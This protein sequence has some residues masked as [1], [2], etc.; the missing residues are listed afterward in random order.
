MN[1]VMLSGTGVSAQAKTEASGLTKK[2]EII[3]S[4]YDE[5]DNCE[6]TVR[7]TK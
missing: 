6:I 3:E 4:T 1:G 2:C 5:N 7:H